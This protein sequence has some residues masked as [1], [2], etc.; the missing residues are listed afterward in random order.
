MKLFIKQ[1]A[2]LCCLLL[3]GGNCLLAQK[4]AFQ[5]KNTT[6]VANANKSVVELEQNN[7]LAIA[8]IIANK[9]AILGAGPSIQLQ[10]KLAKT[11]NL[12]ITHNWYKQYV[13]G[14]Q[15]LY[16]EISFHS[17]AN[18]KPH[19]VTGNIINENDEAAARFATASLNKGSLLANA[20]RLFKNKVLA[21][22]THPL[23]FADGATVLFTDSD[24]ARNNMANYI[25]AFVIDVELDNWES[26]RLVY[27]AGSMQLLRKTPL[28]QTDCFA[29]GKRGGDL[30]SITGSS[31]PTQ[32]G[33]CTY[34]GSFATFYNG[35]QSQNTTK[36]GNLY[37]LYNDCNATP[38]QIYDRRQDTSN[39]NTYIDYTDADNNWIATEG[40]QIY[41]GMKKTMD[42]YKTTFGR[43]GM[44]NDNT[45][46]RAW[47]NWSYKSYDSVAKV[48]SVSGTN[49]S[50]Y[51]DHNMV[52]GYGFDNAD[53]T[54]DVVHLDVT[55]HEFTHGVT[56]EMAGIIYEKESGA[57]NEAL[58][59]IFAKC[60]DAYNRGAN[61]PADWLIR[62]SGTWTLRSMSSPESYGQ[63]SI[64]RV[65]PYFDTEGCVPNSSNDNCG[66]HG[67]SGV[68]NRWFYMLATN[69]SATFSRTPGNDDM[70]VSVSGIG[71]DKMQR[72][73]YQAFQYYGTNP[74]FF[75]ARNATLQAAKDLYGN[76]SPEAIMVGKAWAYV[77]VGTSSQSYN[78]LR[79]GTLNSGTLKGA[80]KLIFTPFF[81]CNS[82]DVN[83]GITVNA[84]AGNAVVM[85]PGFTAKA[86]SYFDAYIQKD[87][88]LYQ[89]LN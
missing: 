1:P 38:L 60:T 70:A 79:C 45:L 66:V 40:T 71:I 12:G 28:F 36:T 53:S 29:N 67:N 80:N 37:K 15:V 57:I 33:T 87:D 4:Q 21:V 39:F 49:A 47:G 46:I 30:L 25:T 44:K 58:S 76:C 77:N 72:I 14:L 23:E 73:M 41:F 51:G 34:N 22:P 68:M 82:T 65:A 48:W 78:A 24:T 16:G 63:P 56:Q 54:D 35:N 81:F 88:C 6:I 26:Y 89:E 32:N 5:F 62:G 18:G 42:Y 13:N 8:D 10:E 9:Q 43:N 27:D 86:G 55:A 19:L 59:D 31:S 84:F 2:F 85:T 50:H 74:T 20:A 64:Y 17:R 11:D 75:T 7:E 52:F 3:L 83:P 61:T 69:G